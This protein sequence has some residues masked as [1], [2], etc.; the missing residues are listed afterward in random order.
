MDIKKSVSEAPE[1]CLKG[2]Q[3]DPNRMNQ[4]FKEYLKYLD[5]TQM[6]FF[7]LCM[8]FLIIAPYCIQN[9][10]QIVEETKRNRPDYVGPAWSDFTLLLYYVPVIYLLKQLTAWCLTDVFERKLPLK[11]Q[12]DLRHMKIEKM[13][14]N[15]F[16]MIYFS[17]ISV[18][19]YFEVVQ[20]L[21]FTTPLIHEG[22]T[23]NNYFKDFPY[24]PYLP[25]TTYY[26]LMNLAY[27]TESTIMTFVKPKNDFYEML[28]HHS[29]TFLIISIAYITNY[30][31][32]AI[33]F[34][35]AF[36]NSDIFIGLIRVFID[37][38]P[39]WC[40]FFIYIGLMCSWIYTRFYI[41]TFEVVGKASLGTFQYATGRLTPHYFMTGMLSVLCV[42]NVYW[43]FL[44]FRMGF[45]FIVNPK[46][47]PKDD[48]IDDKKTILRKHKKD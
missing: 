33:P 29:M 41:I 31:N 17:A 18:Y 9:I 36:D 44:L 2:K 24:V 15:F 48:Q 12:G 32:I 38:V 46:D 7:L 4:K 34:M 16:K 43:M 42:L 20:K 5:S 22:G 30:N 11:Y 1:K 27:H 40:T 23:W 6:F 37:I 10:I 47:G 25:A 8:P 39:G 45:R 21:P 28:C 26:C 35:L 14:D 13:C 3:D 19:G